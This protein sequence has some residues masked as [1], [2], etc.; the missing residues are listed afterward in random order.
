MS[1]QLLV[2]FPVTVMNRIL[3]NKSKMAYV[4]RQSRRQTVAQS[5][6][7]MHAKEPIALILK[8]IC[9]ITNYFLN[10]AHLTW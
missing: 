2:Q 1:K 8:F 7:Y 3:V 4:Q 5:T 10:K 9:K 6:L